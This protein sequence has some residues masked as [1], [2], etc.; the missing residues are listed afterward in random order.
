MNFIKSFLLVFIIFNSKEIYSQEKNECFGVIYAGASKMNILYLGIENPI[1][2][3]ICGVS[4]GKLNLKTDNGTIRKEF[5]GL[6]KIIPIKLGF[7]KII[8]SY[9]GGQITEFLFRVK[10]IPKPELFAI[11]KD[12]SKLNLYEATIN[13]IKNFSIFQCK[14]IG[15]D[16][17]VEYALSDSIKISI[18]HPNGTWESVNHASFMLNDDASNLLNKIGKNDILTIENINITPLKSKQDIRLNSVFIRAK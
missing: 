16:F 9:D 3:S 11:L 5:N 18:G 17:E 15:F 10:E 1:D 4:S 2:A 6:Y 14:N 8:C 7:C 12:G 13:E